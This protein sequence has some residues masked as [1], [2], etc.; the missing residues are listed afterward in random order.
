MSEIK[1]HIELMENFHRENINHGGFIL[2]QANSQS[3]NFKAEKEPIALIAWG[4]QGD[5]EVQV[6]RARTD[7]VGNNHWT[8]SECGLPISPDLNVNVASMPYLK[9]G[10]K[11]SLTATNPHCL[12]DDVG[13]FFL[14]YSGTNESVVI[15]VLPDSIPKCK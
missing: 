14:V 13:I 2:S 11:V 8:K 5:D 6:F 12:I 10:K 15:E 9:N 4:L 1:T 3:Y 7:S